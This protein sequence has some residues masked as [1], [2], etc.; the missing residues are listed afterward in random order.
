MHR[1]QR[2]NYL[3]RIQSIT[4]N[5]KQADFLEAILYNLERDGVKV[6]GM[7]GGRGGGKSK[8]LADTV[9]IMQEELPRAKGQFAC[10]TVTAAKRSLTPGLKETWCDEERW[11]M[12]PY[13]FSTGDGDFVLWREPPKEWDRPYQVPDDWK[14]C[15]S[16]PNG[17][18]IE[19]CGYKLD[20]TSHRGRNDD[21][22]LIDEG[23]LFKE[24]WLKI[25]FPC[26]RAN[27]LKFQSNLHWLI[28]FFSSP[29][30]GATGQW[31]Y[32]YEKLAKEN[33]RKYYFTFIKTADNQVFLPHDYID[34][35]K[36]SLTKLEFDVE[37]LGKRLTR[38]EKDFYPAFIR[39]V[40]TT[41]D[42]NY[43]ADKV[44]ELSIDFNAHFTSLTAWQQEGRQCDCV[45]DVFVKVPE[46][47]FNMT[48]TLAKKFV[49]TYKEHRKKVV[50]L[51]GDRNGQNKSAQAKFK[52]GR[53]QSLFDEFAEVLIQAGWKVYIVPLTF[54]PEGHEKHQL[55]HG[56]FLENNLK[57][58][59]IRFNT[60]EAAS[61]IVSI[62]SAPIYADYSKDKRSET[63]GIDQERAT[64]LS[65]T[66]DYYIIYK[67]KNAV[68][69]SQSFGISFL[70]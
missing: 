25:A 37:V 18:V 9:K 19:L 16:F 46:E 30:Y 69:H 48:Q 8:L 49:N 33:P 15:I 35:L 43:N 70:E 31:M 2:M 38:P 65:D 22:L 10:I 21:F 23:L 32:K 29:P 13:D 27:K 68:Y 57:E 64:H 28:A 34:N 47:G 40:H 53:M 61:T 5:E 67:K 3:E 56:I 54:N 14:N 51:T 11:G 41:D 20:P 1:K 55:I 44:L 45:K 63:S 12:K 26:V 62:E 50:Y 58:L 7:V 4:V 66:V 59:Y 24:E 36:K 42:N 17:F 60:I 39:G 6:A 52:N